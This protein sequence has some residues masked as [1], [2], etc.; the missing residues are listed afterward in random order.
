MG[1]PKVHRG[2]VVFRRQN[3]S[4]IRETAL[5]PDEIPLSEGKCAIPLPPWLA[6]TLAKAAVL[7]FLISDPP[8]N[9]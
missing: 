1:L 6:V 4:S 9:R 5:I 3:P 8:D 2:F 7:C